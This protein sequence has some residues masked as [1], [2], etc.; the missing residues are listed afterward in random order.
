MADEKRQLPALKDIYDG[1]VELKKE[2]DLNILLNQEPK[3]QW[4]RQHPMA[5]NVKYIPIEVIEYLL[6][7]I[8]IRW[9][10]EIKMVQII[11]NS[12]VV[13]VRLH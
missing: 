5:S 6:T 4:I 9:H 2:N 11:A 13:T 1:T 3:V 12:V 7:S 10:V 8:F